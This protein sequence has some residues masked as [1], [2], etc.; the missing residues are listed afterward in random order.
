MPSPKPPRIARNPA[1]RYVAV[2][3]A[4]LVFGGIAGA[5]AA[6]MG[7]LRAVSVAMMAFVIAL[8]MA[9]VI[10]MCVWWWR[11]LDEAAREAHKWAWWWG[12]TFGLAIGG[13][14]LL[15]GMVVIDAEQAQTAFAAY[16][17]VDLIQ[18]GVFSV[19]LVQTLGYAFAWVFWW[20][21]H[22]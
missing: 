21:R 4:C 2:M 17:P 3:A 15:T 12:S 1:L 14:V 8:G 9:G 22:R 13:I 11:G 20:A 6:V 7:E 10:W 18:G 16:D 5:G 19:I